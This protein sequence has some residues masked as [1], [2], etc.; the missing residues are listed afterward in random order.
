[1]TDRSELFLAVIAGATLLIALV[2]VSLI[3]AAGLVAR[4]LGRLVDHVEREITPIFGQLNAI[5][6]DAARATSL[7]AAQVERADQLFADVAGRIEQ[8]LTSVQ[9]SLQA[10][11]REGRAL[12]SALRVA[13]QTIRDV[14]R[15]GRSRQGR[16]D[17]NVDEDALFI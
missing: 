15:A 3:V 11:A 14:R 9:K 7:A 8:T 16:P 17:G 10:P 2:Q 12:M 5:G 1:V 13:L 6:R 4:R